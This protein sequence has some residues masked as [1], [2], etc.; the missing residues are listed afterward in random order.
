V[1]A[2]PLTPLLT[3]AEAAELLHLSPFT[4]RQYATNGVL[5][6][7]RVNARVLRFARADVAALMA[8]AKKR[9]RPP[10]KTSESEN[11]G[12]STPHGTA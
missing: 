4:I 3:T 12:A 10:A 7:V 2:P 9:T 1:H 8:P 6:V 11:H 5:P